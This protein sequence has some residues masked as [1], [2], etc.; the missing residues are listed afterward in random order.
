MNVRVVGLPLIAAGIALIIWQMQT[1]PGP[2]PIPAATWRVKVGDEYRQAKN[3]HELAQ[4]TAVRLSFTCS[5]SCYVY[6]F[7]HSPTDGTLLMFPS[8]ELKRDLDNPIP[9][10][11]ATLPGQFGGKDVT[12]T[13]R[14][15]VLGL[16]TFVAVAAKEP[17]ADLEKLSR[18]LR[19]WSN[20]VLPDRSLQITNPAGGGEVLGKPGTD[21]PNAILKRA[22]D[23]T[24]GETIVNGPMQPDEH[25]AGVWSCSVRVKEA[26]NPNQKK[27]GINTGPLKPFDVSQPPKEQPGSKPGGGK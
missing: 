7:G 22:A 5:E 13:T 21:W 25:I 27:G 2:S 16:T 6:V 24:T 3:Y 20:S 1:Q 23:R 10:G 19:R 17:I 9:A 26:V 15:D 18:Q 4:E 11:Q 14:A 12:W 8:P